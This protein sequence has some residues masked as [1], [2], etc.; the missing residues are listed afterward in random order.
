MYIAGVDYDGSSRVVA[1]PPSPG[2]GGTCFE[3]EII[4]DSTAE[5]DEEFL[6]NFQISAGSDAQI[7]NVG[8]TC[9]RIIDDDEGILYAV[10]IICLA[11]YICMLWPSQLKSIIQTIRQSIIHK[12][13][14]IIAL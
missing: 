8:F 5:S 9:V 4:D 2:P 3:I 1:I 6:V 10:D 12:L 7:G 13:R 14:I 11:L